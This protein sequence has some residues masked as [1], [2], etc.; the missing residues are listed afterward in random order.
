MSKHDEIATECTAEKS[1]CNQ[2]LSKTKMSLPYQS[3]LWLMTSGNN[4]DGV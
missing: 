3:L 2:S 1:D 4:G